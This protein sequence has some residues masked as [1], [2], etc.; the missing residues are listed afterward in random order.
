MAA[1]LTMIQIILLTLLAAACGIDPY[2]SGLQLSKPVIAGFL[3]GIIMG[4]IQ[5]GLV[6]GSTPQLMVLGV[7]TFGGASIPDFAT[8]AIIGT[9]LGVVSGKGIQFAIGISV[10][11]GL[12]MVQLDVF[13]RFCNVYFLHRVDKHIQN[14][15][16]SKINREAWLSLL[17]IGLSRALPVGISLIFGNSVVNAVLKYAPDWLMGGL[18]LAGAVL[19]VVGIAILLHYLPVGKFVAFLIAGYLL[20]A[21]LKIPMMGIALFGLVC[22]LI[23]FKQLK[24]KQA[25]MKNVTKTAIVAA[26]EITEG[27]IEDDEL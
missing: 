18:K 21:Y 12:L 15:E 5:T 6:V 11:V 27:E 9:A 17:P 24:E 19:P 3:A 26:E 4:D 22:A 20:A 13:A 25:M 10:P 14:K 23:H 2:I 7:G 8:G 16:F 1:D